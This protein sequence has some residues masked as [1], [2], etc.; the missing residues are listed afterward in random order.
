MNMLLFNSAY[1]MLNVPYNRR[2]G[3]YNA[4]EES[5]VKGDSRPFLHWFFR[6][7]VRANEFY[8]ESERHASN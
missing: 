5:S 2:R 3:Y 1:P 7:Y 4:L 6:R 8:L